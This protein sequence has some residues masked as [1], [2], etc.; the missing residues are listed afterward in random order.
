MNIPCS[1]PVSK[2]PKHSRLLLGGPV[3]L[4]GIIRDSAATFGLWPMILQGSPLLRVRM[5]GATDTHPLRECTLRSDSF[6]LAFGAHYSKTPPGPKLHPPHSS[7]SAF[8]QNCRQPPLC[9]LASSQCLVPLRSPRDVDLPP[10]HLLQ[11]VPCTVDVRDSHGVSL[12][13]REHD[14]PREHASEQD[15]PGDKGN[16]AG[17]RLFNVCHVLPTPAAK[18]ALRIVIAVVL[19]SHPRNV[20]VLGCLERRSRPYLAADLRQLSV[21]ADKQRGDARSH[22]GEQEG[23]V[24]TNS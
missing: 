15:E 5:H 20:P 21:Q 16:Q 24:A 4:E 22:D 18:S 6:R 3:C 2:H 19:Y 1:E 8:H 14:P 9:T 10:H 12:L 13:V 23:N 11:R 17:L 7:S